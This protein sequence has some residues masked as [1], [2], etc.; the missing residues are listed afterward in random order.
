[1]KSR[2]VLITGPQ[3]AG[4]STYVKELSL[5]LGMKMNKDKFVHV[6][7]KICIWGKYNMERRLGEFEYSSGGGNDNVS[8]KY[9]WTSLFNC[10]TV[11]ECKTVIIEGV[12]HCWRSER[13]RDKVGM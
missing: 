3:G 2:L 7:D 1:M 8:P 4:K 13:G 5:K 6:K 11:R 9:V 10:F 12:I